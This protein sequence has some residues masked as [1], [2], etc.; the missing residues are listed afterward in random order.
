MER[1]YQ[2]YLEALGNGGTGVFPALVVTGQQPSDLLADWFRD[3]RSAPFV[4]LREGHQAGFALVRRT[5]VAR[6]GPRAAFRL[7]EF[8]VHQPLRLRGIGR[9]AAL[10]LFD[11]FEGQWTITASPRDRDAVAFWR[12]VVGGYARS[13]YR[14]RLEDGELQYS[15]SSRGRTT[16]RE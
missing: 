9:E 2:D 15:F 14:E 13:R 3:E 16:G 6:N 4:I 8:Y 11:R 12:R 5:S 1:V 7:S 10:L